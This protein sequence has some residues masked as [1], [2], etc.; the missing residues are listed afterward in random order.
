[1]QTTVD[2]TPQNTTIDTSGIKAVTKSGKPKKPQSFREQYLVH[3]SIPGEWGGSPITYIVVNQRVCQL[4]QS[5]KLKPGDIIMV[6]RV[7][8][9]KPSDE[10][11]VAGGKTVI[12]NK[13][14]LMRDDGEAGIADGICDDADYD[15]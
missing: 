1:M 13:K 10:V 14:A 8:A 3:R 5:L 15:D 6:E 11:N 2:T 9:E 12:K 7:K 4:P